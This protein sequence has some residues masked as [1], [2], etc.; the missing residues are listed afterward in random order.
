MNF[1]LDITHMAVTAALAIRFGVLAATLPLLDMRT[2]PPLWRVALA[3][4]FAASLAPG[5]AAGLPAGS[6]DLSWPALVMEALRSLVVGLLL[7]F[8]INLTFTTVRMA[9]SIAGMQI[10]FAIVNSFDPMSNS[11]ISVISQMYYLLAVLLFFVSGTHH[12]LVTSMFQSCIVVPPFGDLNPAGGSWFLLKEFSSVFAIGFRIAAPV[13]LVLLLVSASM[14]V[15]VK[16]VPQI[17]VLIVGFPV[18]IAVGLATLGISLVF[19]HQV[20][21]QMFLGMEEQLAKVL[22]AMS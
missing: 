19:F 8:T 10:G 4:S 16:T 12:V 13:V 21:D 6:V 1:E 5:I 17:N 7:G 9:G 3:F 18:K 11:Q 14:G 20:V 15:I 22:L 2:V